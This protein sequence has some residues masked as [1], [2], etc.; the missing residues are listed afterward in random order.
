MKA[1]QVISWIS[2]AGALA[3]AVGIFYI[4]EF[5]LVFLGLLILNLL[6][7]ILVRKG[8]GKP[9]LTLCRVLVGALFI[10]SSFTKGVDPL[11]TKYKILDYLAVY[12][13]QWFNDIA[14]LLSMGLILAE[15]I[16]GICLLTNIFPRLAVLG[17]TI[18]M[19]FFTT[20]TLFDAVYNLVPDCGCFGTAVKMTNWQTFYKNLVIDSVLLA[21]IF[22]NKQLK[23]R[24]TWRGQFV[25]GCLYA[26]IFLLFEIYNYRHLPVVDF[27]NWKVG[28][29]MK[30][31]NEEPAK[32]YLTFRN[33]NT[34][35][36]Q[37]YLSPDYPW[38]D[39]V[40]SSQ[41]EFVDQRM[42]GGNDYLGFSALDA[43]GNDVTDMI[44]ETENLLMFTSHD[45]TKV[46]EEEWEEVKT[47]TEAADAKG[48]YVVWS[49]ANSPE[50]VAE[51][52][53]KYDFLYEV[54]FGDELEIKT[55]V[56]FN[57]GLIWLDNGLV[58]DKWSAIDFDKALKKIQE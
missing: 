6:L 39:S 33:I 9:Q 42:E 25:I 11:G 15:F 56:R 7:P 13:L 58:V 3:S 34:G 24:L 50:Y 10:F 35:E 46:T 44:L 51:L 43:D 30:V 26:L 54:Y 8:Y 17:A 12:N 28:K 37:E 55:I 21:L 32:I 14:M 36:T 49:V 48:Y 18:L 40:W 16:V 47:I 1:K 5:N 2:I 4:P 27:M 57:P 38:N 52:Q 31:E 41:W 23:N 20:T 22:N 53:E 45:L 19:L 29:Q